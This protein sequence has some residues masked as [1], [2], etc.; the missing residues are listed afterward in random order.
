MKITQA[1]AIAQVLEVGP[2]PIRFQSEA[3]KVVRSL[4]VPDLWELA[5]SRLSDLAGTEA[6]R[7][8]RE[9][10]QAAE[11]SRKEQPPSEWEEQRMAREVQYKEREEQ[12]QAQQLAWEASQPKTDAFYPKGYSGSKELLYFHGWMNVRDS[13]PK[14][15]RSAAKLGCPCS[16]CVDSRKSDE[17]AKAEM[18]ESL[19]QFKLRIE[20]HVD[21]RAQEKL[22]QWTRE[23]L[24]TPFSLYD[25]TV[26][27]WGQATVEQHELVLGRMIKDAVGGLQAASRHKQAVDDLT[28]AGADCLDDLVAA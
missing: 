26:V 3:L 16:T 1:E 20:E 23:L 9:A 2:Y 24:D 27:P 19:R 6:R 5:A 17:R 11:Q 13:K 12:E 22:V 4:D 7:I 8:T 10:E 18:A 25:K 28:E 21:V 14:R 15:N